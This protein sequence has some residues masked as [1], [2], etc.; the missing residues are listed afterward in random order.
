[1]SARCYSCPLFKRL[2]RCNAI[3]PKLPA[4]GRVARY[5]IVGEA[6]GWQEVKKGE[7]FIGKSGQELRG[8][9]EAAGIDI[10]ECILANALW[11]APR[12]SKNAKIG[13]PK[14]KEVRACISHTFELISKYQPD[15]LILAG[16]KAKGGFT[17]GLPG[18]KKAHGR[19][20][21]INRAPTHVIYQ[22]FRTWLD[23]QPPDKLA[24][25]R[26]LWEIE[27]D[28]DAEGTA[29]ATQ[30][31]YAHA[32]L[33]YVPTF[34]DLPV[35]PMVHPSFVIRQNNP[36]RWREQSVRAL[37]RARMLVTGET[38]EQERKQRYWA[39]NDP[40]EWN[41]YVDETLEMY[42]SG[43]I[44][45]VSCDIET[46]EELG[47]ENVFAIPFHVETE[48]WVIQFSRTPYEG[49]MV[50]VSHPHSAFNNPFDFAE[51]RAG[52]KRLL[53]E[54]PVVG[55]NF[56][57][58]DAHVL[59]CKLGVSDFTLIGDTKT[60][61]YWLTMGRGL[62]LD[63]DTLGSR[64]LNTYGHKRKALDWRSRNPDARFV[65][66]PW[67]LQL[68]YACGDADI[69]LRLYYHLR[70]QI[71]KEDRWA[72]YYELHHGTHGGMDFVMQMR[73]SGMPC[74][75]SRLQELMT[76]FPE[77]IERAWRDLHTSSY[78]QD[79]M[80]R[81]MEEANRE[82]REKNRSIDDEIAET[83]SS[84]RRRKKIW[85]WE[86][87]FHDQ[88]NWLNYN[89]W[90]QIEDLWVNVMG[91]DFDLIDAE[92]GEVSFKDCS[93]CKEKWCK[94]P[95]NPGCQDCEFWGPRRPGTKGRRC[96]SCRKMYCDPRTDEHN[97]NVIIDW[98]NQK[99]IAAE[100]V[101]KEQYASDHPDPAVLRDAEERLF[102]YGEIKRATECLNEIKGLDKNYGTY[103]KNIPDVTPDKP[104]DDG[105][106]SPKERTIP[107]YQS[108]CDYPRPWTIHPSIVLDR[109]ATGRSASR[110]P[111]GQNFPKHKADKD[112]DVKTV[113]TSH[114][115]SI[116][117]TPGS[118]LE[119]HVD[120]KTVQD[121]RLERLEKRR[122]KGGG[123]LLGA[124]YSQIEVRVAVIFARA[125][126]LAA[127]INEGRDIHTFMTSK[128]Y[129]I[130]ESEVTPDKRTPTKR[131]TFGILY[132]QGERGL[133]GRL[134]CSLD[135][136]KE[137]IELFYRQMPEIKG[138]IDEQHRFLKKNGYVV[139]KF[140][141]RR[142][143]PDV[144]SDD[145]KAVAEAF[146]QAVNTPIQSTAADMC[147]SAG[148]RTWKTMEALNLESYHRS[149]EIMLSTLP[150]ITIHDSLYWD[151]APGELLDMLAL[152]YYQMVYRPYELW[153]WII[154]KPEADFEVCAPTWGDKAD[155]SLI[156][157]DETL[158]QDYLDLYGTPDVL[159][160]I[161]DELG[162][163]GL[164]PRCDV[165]DPHPKDEEAE[166]GKR[167]WIVNVR[168]DSLRLRLEGR[169]LLDSKKREISAA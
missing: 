51:W 47:S 80:H 94:C 102:R 46:S 131:T 53:A 125:M 65:D 5:L 130:P 44:E 157:N 98:C 152:T 86:E 107:I 108:F 4:E 38:T 133:S 96:S 126:E 83:G 143:I 103:V 17:K 142:Y 87:W 146:R 15:V 110:N 29:A 109:T 69:T 55:H 123:I 93:K 63:L 113:Y 127:A 34:L 45:V 16:N 79:W 112:A 3:R 36:E 129:Q 84:R 128:V 30:M 166:K 104:D 149:S 122:T 163:G 90:M 42:R 24:G 160:A 62:A 67:D 39:I 28:P 41:E 136:A 156:W 155:L 59:R 116:L 158:V 58:F 85:T 74:R 99:V 151:V 117:I 54:V 11:C 32:L 100:L 114:W 37:V 134:R 73:W 97:R 31:Q 18:I 70:E 105:P 159:E 101:L 60:M 26:D 92:T 144:Y 27:F 119:A 91:L 150:Y 72:D 115:S 154:C 88:E 139:S 167:R 78:V 35:I 118:K 7:V 147:F 19:Q 49:M 161:C 145:Q 137:L 120:G 33:D 8:N 169:K 20:F 81:N 168:P 14:A 82:A 64:Y 22:D 111:N 56:Y 106:W 43:E 121:V 140:G 135:R 148:G 23:Q 71:A 10:D 141:R 162:A 1:M 68:L 77:R 164:R 153:D 21:R 13:R 57:D 66:M 132:G 25:H 52:L 138:W 76:V 75:P 165:D 6:P 61:A 9:L 124:D 48:V 12:A 89:S 2:G 95:P 50:L 40:D